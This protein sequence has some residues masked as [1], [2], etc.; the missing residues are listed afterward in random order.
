MNTFKEYY[1]KKFKNKN[2]NEKRLK[3]MEYVAEHE[4]ECRF[5]GLKVKKRKYLLDN[6]C[7]DLFEELWEKTCK[8][9]EDKNI[10]PELKTNFK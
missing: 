2:D 5:K 6:N 10:R 1:D 4:T 3:F 7:S 8:L 9:F